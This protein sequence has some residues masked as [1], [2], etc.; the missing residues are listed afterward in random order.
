MCFVKSCQVYTEHSSHKF[1]IRTTVSDPAYRGYFFGTF[2]VCRQPTICSNNPKAQLV[3]FVSLIR[4]FFGTFTSDSL[5]NDTPHEIATKVTPVE[6]FE[7]LNSKGVGFII[8][9]VVWDR[10]N[11]KGWSITTETQSS[12]LPFVQSKVRTLFITCSSAHEMNVVPSFHFQMHSDKAIIN[13][14]Y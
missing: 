1:Q 4:M 2:P 6:A 7:V 13:Q 10:L 14:I 11:K 12:A 8:M 5:G 9:D 3:T